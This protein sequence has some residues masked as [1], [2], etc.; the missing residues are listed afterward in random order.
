MRRRSFMLV[1][2]RAAEKANHRHCRLLR[3]RRERPCDRRAEQRRSRPSPLIRTWRLLF[4]GSFFETLHGAPHRD[5]A[6]LDA[7]AG[8]IILDE[9][10]KTLLGLA[11]TARAEKWLRRST[12]MGTS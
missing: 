8:H 4:L 9:H 12:G 7:L 11:I 3:A 2:R 10:L 5:N 1:R 6:M